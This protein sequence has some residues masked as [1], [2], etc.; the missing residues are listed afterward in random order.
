MHSQQIQ[1]CVNLLHWSGYTTIHA[2][3]MHTVRLEYKNKNKTINSYLFSFYVSDSRIVHYAR[4]LMKLAKL[5]VGNFRKRYGKMHL[6]ESLD[7]EAN[8]AT[9]VDQTLTSDNSNKTLPLPPIELT[10]CLQFSILMI[11]SFGVLLVILCILMTFLEIYHC[12]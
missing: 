9:K 7:L 8:E 4:Q 11:V 5:Q 12:F 1:G 3:C 2:F 10:A 6:I